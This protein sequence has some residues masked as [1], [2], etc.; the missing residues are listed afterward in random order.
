MPPAAGLLQP[1]P[2]RIDSLN[3]AY[4]SDNVHITHL[5]CNYAK[6]KFGVDD[7]EEWLEVVS[8]GILQERQDAPQTD[9]APWTDDVGTVKVNSR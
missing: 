7:F 8:G 2:D 4:G 6:N 9:A 5:G 3:T 1:S